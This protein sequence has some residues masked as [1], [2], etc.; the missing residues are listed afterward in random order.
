MCYIRHQPPTMSSVAEDQPPSHHPDHAFPQYSTSTSTDE[1][2]PTYLG[3][4][5]AVPPNIH[6][7]NIKTHARSAREMYL[8]STE[9]NKRLY[10]V[11]FGWANSSKTPNIM[12]VFKYKQDSGGGEDGVPYG[13]VEMGRGKGGEIQIRYS[14]G[15]DNTTTIDN[16][17]R[18]APKAGGKKKVRVTVTVGGVK[19]FWTGTEEYEDQHE[20]QGLGKG[21][22]KVGDVELSN[23]GGKVL[24]V[25]LNDYKASGSKDNSVGILNG[26][27]RWELKMWYI[28]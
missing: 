15:E 23:D 28:N 14:D 6:L 16:E 26:S 7:L 21:K 13:R 2:A 1:R 17:E 20:A 24:A 8:L 25:F 22:G 9:T 11:K 5:N 10:N 12:N 4:K 3:E 27:R 19:Y 18:I